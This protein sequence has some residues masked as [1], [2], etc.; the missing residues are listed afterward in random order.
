MRD[1]PP[2]FQAEPQLDLTVLARRD[3]ATGVVA[4]TLGHADR[5]SLPPWAAGSH[6]DVMLDG[7]TRQYSLTGPPGDGS[8]W[9]IAVLRE[10]HGRGGSRAIVD[11]LHEGSSVQTRGPRNH[12]ELDSAPRYLFIAGGIGITPIRAMIIEAEAANSEWRLLYGG[13]TE[14]SMAY[15]DE[16]RAEYGDRVVIQPQDQFGMLDLVTFL[17]AP[18]DDTLVYCCGPEPLLNAVE[19]T[20]ADWRP[21]AL[22]VER[23]APRSD[24][25][26]GPDTEFQVELVQTG[27]TVTVPA[28]S[29][30]LGVAEDAGAFVTSSCEEGTCGSCET[31][32][33]SGVPYHRDSILSS[34]DR[35]ANDTMMICVSRC[36][37]ARLVLDL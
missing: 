21:G 36:K 5:S 26:S 24:V 14:A 17:G 6:I 8:L 10:E 1:M 25:D 31:K 7:T 20:C 29:S 3:A 35:A 11:R 4:L 32:I 37:G 12:F 27:V 2:D 28:G 19:A 34:E 18:A 16:L 13:R 22:R 15:V 9:E 33:L 23:F 30:I